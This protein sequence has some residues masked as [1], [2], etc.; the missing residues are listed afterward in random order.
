MPAAV[1]SSVRS[2]V[3][4]DGLDDIFN[5]DAGIDATFNPPDQDWSAQDNANNSNTNQ[6]Q[7]DVPVDIDEEV[8]VTKK[9][10]PVAKLDEDRLL[11]QQG[12]PKLR[13][14]AKDRIQIKGKGHEFS[15]MARLLNTYQLWL[16]DL[17]PKAKFM[18]GVSM[19]EK[20]GHK[21][22]MQMMRK[23]WIQES[24]PKPSRDE[25]EDDF[26]VPNE[27]AAVESNNGPTAEESASNNN[28]RQEAQSNARAQG[29]N[30]QNPFGEEEPDED[31]LDALLAEGEN[32]PA[33]TSKQHNTQPAEEQE[34]DED[35]MD[36]LMAE[37]ALNDSA[38]RS[39]F[40]G[41]VSSNT[42]KTAAQQPHDEFDDD[43]EAMA[44]M[45]W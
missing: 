20:L 36:A 33:T 23:E 10:K 34:P 30:R 16:D 27:D 45:D 4:R 22:R 6:R 9:R 44:G 35:E 14:I 38:P 37:D 29:G 1:P 40:G 8:K 17:F 32:A 41:P 15:D 7:E 18:D 43:E 24:K 2:T 11:S 31:E 42:T 26:V 13:K 5:Y 3:E 21:K 12:I 19:I 25:E 39:L 28:S